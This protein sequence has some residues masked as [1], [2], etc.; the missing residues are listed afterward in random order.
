MVF[1]YKPRAQIKADPQ[2]VGGICQE[3]ESSGGLS[4]KRLVDVS[5][6]ENAPLHKEFEWDDSVAAELHRESQAS[7]II[8]NLIVEP[9]KEC[10]APIRA[11]VNV[12]RG[13]RLYTSMDVVVNTPSMMETLMEQA[14]KDLIAFK[15]KYETLPELKK[16]FEVADEFISR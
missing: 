3:L 10:K 12:D 15:S 14:K 4:A 2:V 11:F 13:S 6:E 16:M 8:R 7:Y 1:N 9:I 5:R